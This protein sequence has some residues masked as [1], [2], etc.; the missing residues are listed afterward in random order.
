MRHLLL[1]ALPSLLAACGEP[2]TAPALT[3]AW[4][5][6]L[7]GGQRD[8]TCQAAG[9][10]TVGLW[11]DGQPAGLDMACGQGAA[12][13]T[14]LAA[15]AHAFTIQGRSAGGQLLQQDWGLVEVGACGETRATLRPG[16][17][18]LRIAYA[19]TSGLC[20]AEDD[21]DHAPGYIW[22]WLEDRT[23]HQLVSR[24]DGS[25]APDSLPCRTEAGQ[26]VVDVPLPWGLYGLRWIQDVR[27]PLSAPSPA[28]QQCA[29]TDPPVTLHAQ[30][31]TTLAVALAPAELACL[32]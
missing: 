13:F 5:F 14:G 24:V 28:Y 25:Q 27:D 32:P 19:T 18:W 22:Y 10:A 30:G 23:T 6:D 16:A 7:A 17:G 1:A 3:V 21:P 12:T 8:A 20:H 31:V 15:G 26:A 29:P 4:R 11:L 2:C 9:V